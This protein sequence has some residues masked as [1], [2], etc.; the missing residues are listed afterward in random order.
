MSN[1]D[2][3]NYKNITFCCDI[4]GFKTKDIKILDI[5]VDICTEE[6]P[7]YDLYTDDIGTQTE[8]FK[9]DIGTESLSDINH[10]ENIE[11]KLK[12]HIWMELLKANTNIRIPENLEISWDNNIKN[13]DNI[14][15]ELEIYNNKNNI[16]SNNTTSKNQRFKPIRS[17]QVEQISSTI[18]KQ[19]EKFDSDIEEELS[20]YKILDEITYQNIL[21]KIK[22][23]KQISK[24]LKELALARSRSL[25]LM[26]MEKYRN[27]IN[28]HLKTVEIILKEKNTKRI[29]YYISQSLTGL[30]V[31]IANLWHLANYVDFESDMLHDLEITLK[32]SE[33]KHLKQYENFNIE[34]IQDRLI[35]YGLALLTLEDMIRISLI[36]PHGY[37]TIVYLE[38]KKSKSEDRYSFYVLHKYIEDKGKREWKMDCRLE[39]LSTQI[40]SQLKKYMIELFRKIYYGI[41]KDN[42]Y[43]VDYASK[44]QITECDLNQLLRNIVTCSKDIEFIK[45]VQKI[46]VENSTYVPI[47]NIDKFNLF[48]DD[49]QQR[50][51]FMQYIENDPVEVMSSLFDNVTMEQLVDLYRNF[52]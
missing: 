29:D 51:R 9:K 3:R 31:R 52:S 7:S 10:N 46:I 32:I 42:D 26:G 18:I 49:F 12:C 48:G 19:N 23:S 22:D 6:N 17:E 4:C 37:N 5:H 24:P 8:N 16:F 38:L 40:S 13:I 25:P 1:S 45:L 14:Q 35:N 36:N 44:C 33:P 27:M 39:H 21:Q 20:Y 11:N 50:N 2:N 30:D 15:K 41:F 34:K 28:D 47:D 43:R